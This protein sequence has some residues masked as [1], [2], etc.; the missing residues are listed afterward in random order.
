M[1][2]VVAVGGTRT[3]VCQHGVRYHCTSSL[4][5]PRNLPRRRETEGDHACE[6]HG[7]DA[8]KISSLNILIAR[9][10]EIQGR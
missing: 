3:N 10:A 2:D 8:I 9:S 4:S 5:K 6:S 7:K 1:H